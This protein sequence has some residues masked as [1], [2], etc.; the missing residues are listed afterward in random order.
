ME[1]FYTLLAY[2][3]KDGPL[4]V[5]EIYEKLL[6][7]DKARPLLK[8]TNWKNSVRH[9]LSSKPHLFSKHSSKY[10]CKRGCL[11]QLNGQYEEILDRN[12]IRLS[13]SKKELELRSFLRT[14][15]FIKKNQQ[16]AECYKAYFPE[17]S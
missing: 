1:T 16:L 10:N 17:V 2:T 4:P 14:L 5:S 12:A 6:K 7:M 9:A 8:S 11:W 13:R 3:L 15:L